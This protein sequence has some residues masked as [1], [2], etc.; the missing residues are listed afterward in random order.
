MSATTMYDS[1]LL[2]FEIHSIEWLWRNKAICDKPHRQAYFE[3]VL[4][5]K[6]EGQYCIDLEKYAL[7][8][9]VVYC[10]PPGRM[11]QFKCDE[12]T[13]G[14]VVS[15]S[16]DFFY[17]SKDPLGRSFYRDV[18]AQFSYTG[19]IKK[20]DEQQE[21]DIR[22]LLS[23]MVKEFDDCLP[24]REEVLSGM[25]KV[26]LIHLRRLPDGVGLV[27]EEDGN[28]ELVN[29]FCSRLE[30]YF[31]TKRTVGEYATD[32]LVSAQLLDLTVR[33][34]TGFPADYHIRQRLILEAKRLAIFSRETIRDIAWRL[35]FQDLGCFS[36]FFKKE[37][38]INFSVFRHKYLG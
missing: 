15:F 14:W 25:L 6:G 23:S 4:V 30:Q 5:T 27:Q 22:H 19:M 11:H 7:S 32:L 38:G 12:T 16:I 24:S 18:L 13:C 34:I 9:N 21:R 33:R 2:P 3:I 20:I 8:E 36:R 17:L 35:G 31:L 26:F 37:A 29:G 28:V 1:A 10:I